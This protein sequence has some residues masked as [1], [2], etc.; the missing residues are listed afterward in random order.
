MNIKKYFDKYNKLLLQVAKENPN[1][2]NTSAMQKW[3]GMILCDFNDETK[4][5][6]I[7][8]ERGTNKAVTDEWM[9][10]LLI[11][12]NRK[13]NSLSILFNKRYGL[14]V[15]PKDMFIKYWC[16][17]EPAIKEKIDIY[18]KEHGNG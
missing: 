3:I 9:I 2:T 15:L 12:K 10:Y 17:T 13:W 5:D 16:D 11:S 1:P 4:N 6:I 7:C 14:P 18:Q 8:K